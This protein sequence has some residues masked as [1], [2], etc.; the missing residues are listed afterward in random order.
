MTGRKGSDLANA[1][2]KGDLAEVKRLVE[3]G[4]DVHIRDD[5]NHTLLHLAAYWGRLK[6]ARYLIE[7]GVNLN[8]RDDDGQFA[9]DYAWLNHHYRTFGVLIQN[10]PDANR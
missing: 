6:V 1:V 7:Q 3:L 5:G 2:K 8:A 10:N 4:A 9:D